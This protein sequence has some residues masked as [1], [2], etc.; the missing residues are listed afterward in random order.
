MTRF[1]IVKLES[2]EGTD[3]FVRCGDDSRDYLFMVVAVDPDGTAEVLDSGYRTLAEA[4]EAWPEA[5]P[6]SERG[7]GRAAEH[8]KRGPR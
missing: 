7:A 6:R 1:V 2:F 8:P 4:I 5:R 3:T